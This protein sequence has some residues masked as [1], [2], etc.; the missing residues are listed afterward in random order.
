LGEFCNT[1]AVFKMKLMMPTT[2]VK[3]DKYMIILI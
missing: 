3:V 1:Y 2:I